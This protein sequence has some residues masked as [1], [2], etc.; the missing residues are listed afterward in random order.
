MYKGPLP[1]S[2]ETT[3]LMMADSIEA[4][5]KSIKNPDESTINEVVEQIIEYQMNRNQYIN[6]N[7]TLKD[8]TAAKKVFKRQLMN[9]FHIR[10]AYPKII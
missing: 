10:V 4:A 2:K 9:R 6:S 3:V 8:I 1:Y 7:I 5:S